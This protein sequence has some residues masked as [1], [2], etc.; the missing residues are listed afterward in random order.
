VRPTYQDLIRRLALSYAG[1]EPIFA[2]EMP[3]GTRLDGAEMTALYREV[4]G[5]PTRPS[6]DSAWY[7][8]PTCSMWQVRTE[9]LSP[10]VP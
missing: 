3:D 6:P 5:E 4:M 2:T 7:Q 8:C 1:G 10:D 9:K